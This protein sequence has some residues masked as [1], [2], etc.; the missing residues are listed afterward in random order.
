MKFKLLGILFLSLI[1]GTISCK[2]SQDDNILSEINS[3]KFNNYKK[4]PVDQN[5]LLEYRNYQLSL[6]INSMKSNNTGLLS[7]P[8]ISKL[9]LEKIIKNYCTNEKNL[10]LENFKYKSSINGAASRDVDEPEDNQCPG[11]LPYPSG[12]GGEHKPITCS[13]TFS[14]L[15]GITNSITGQFTMSGT[16]I[17]TGIFGISGMGGTWSPFG[18]LGQT[19]SQGVTTYT[20]YYQQVI[21]GPYGTQATQ[22][23]ILYGNIY[24]GACTVN[25]MPFNVVLP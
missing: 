2:K 23:Y 13:G 15:T 7:I 1:I 5:L 22:M 21:T 18:T 10:L 24:Q 16:N 25:G 12:G 14:G 19:V 17:T 4:E 8:A 11:C 20:Q 3:D 6:E 9:E